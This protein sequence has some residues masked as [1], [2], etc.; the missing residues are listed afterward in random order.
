MFWVLCRKY[1]Y[2]VVYMYISMRYVDFISSPYLLLFGDDRV[3][4]T[5][6]QR[7]LMQVVLVMLR[8]GARDSMGFITMFY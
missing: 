4:G 1:R 5:R 7:M 2:M 3:R 8:R 6:E